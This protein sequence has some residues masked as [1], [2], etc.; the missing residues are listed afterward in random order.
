[1]ASKAEPGA[2]PSDV[3]GE[4]VERGGSTKARPARSVKKQPD[5]VKAGTLPFSCD[6]VQ[7]D[8]KVMPQPNCKIVLLQG[9]ARAPI[10][11][12]HT[13]TPTDTHTRTN[14]LSA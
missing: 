4:N 13:S 11:T 7:V 12:V 5:R 10:R 1:M 2:G 8:G 6:L 9:R 3:K 14:I